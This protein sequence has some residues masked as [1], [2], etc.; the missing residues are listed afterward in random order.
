MTNTN[1]TTVEAEVR[2]PLADWLTAFNHKN[3]DAFYRL[4]DPEIV[5]AN[6][7]APLRRGLDQVRDSFTDAFATPESRISFREEALFASADLA[8]ITG[9]YHFAMLAVDDSLTAGAS[10]RVAL[11]YRR[12]ADGRWLLTFDI[13]NTPPDAADYR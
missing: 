4:Y 8:L 12:A 1:T 2:A 3:P 10:G 9:T 6:E 7:H 5:Y 13:D 11:L